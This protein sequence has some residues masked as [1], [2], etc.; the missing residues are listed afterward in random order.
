MQLNTP[1]Q[2]N[3]KP[4]LY[5]QHENISIQRKFT[6]MIA[7]NGIRLVSK[8]ES[9][10]EKSQ[11]HRLTKLQDAIVIYN[12]KIFIIFYCFLTHFII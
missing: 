10:S 12:K 3:N 5:L 9:Q 11:S 8:Y 2:Q 4:A 7:T 1:L 6:K